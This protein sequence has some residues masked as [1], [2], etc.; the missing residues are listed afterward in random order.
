MEMKMNKDWNM[1]FAFILTDEELFDLYL[2]YDRISKLIRCVEER[3]GLAITDM[4]IHSGA[5]FRAKALLAESQKREDLKNNIL[6][7]GEII[8]VTDD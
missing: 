3:T 5:Y 2:S 1:P 7:P 6:F 8:S 4:E